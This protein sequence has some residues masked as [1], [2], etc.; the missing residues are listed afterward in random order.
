[1]THIIEQFATYQ[2][3]EMAKHYIHELNSTPTFLRPAD[4]STIESIL[5]SGVRNKINTN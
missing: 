2:I 4:L 1:M 3:I 5:R